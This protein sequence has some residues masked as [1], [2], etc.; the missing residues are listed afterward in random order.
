[1]PRRGRRD[2]PAPSTS[3]TRPRGGRRPDGRRG[4][5]TFCSAVRDG[6]RLNAWK[7]KPTRSRRSSV[8]RRSRSARSS[9]VPPR[10]TDPEVGRSRPAAHCRRGRLARAGGPITAVRRC[11]RRRRQ[12]GVEG[13]HR[14]VTRPVQRRRR[15]AAGTPRRPFIVFPSFGAGPR[16]RLA[17][18][19]H[20]TARDR[21]GA[22]R[23]GEN[24]G[25]A[26]HTPQTPTGPMAAP[27]ARVL[28]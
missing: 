3:R 22:V 12:N 20:E 13:R 7:T 2:R 24:E 26:S 6:S 10:R 28:R 25:G 15:S 5:A 8:S 1:M 16:C 9:S 4:S 14:A 27:H 21:P 11:P 17:D 23:Q 19:H 18:Q